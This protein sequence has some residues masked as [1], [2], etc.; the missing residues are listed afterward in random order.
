MDTQRLEAFAVGLSRQAASNVRPFVSRQPS[1]ETS[2]PTAAQ[3]MK[4]AVRHAESLA[5]L[6]VMAA[7]EA[8]TRE[9]LEAQ[10]A[11]VEGLIESLRRELFSVL[12]VQGDL[13]FQK[14]SRN[15]E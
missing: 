10:R 11:T 9:E 14:F 8:Q 5:P 4:S 15:Q 2:A 12:A 1:E 6:L 3:L 13:T 7:N